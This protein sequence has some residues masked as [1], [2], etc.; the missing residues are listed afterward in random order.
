MCLR[1]NTITDCKQFSVVFRPTII[2]KY[3]LVRRESL[4]AAA[5]T[6]TSR[7]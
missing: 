7:S 2:P 1:I 4:A 6:F 3:T 5:A